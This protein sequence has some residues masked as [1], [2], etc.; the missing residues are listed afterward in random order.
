MRAENNLQGEVTSL[1]ALSNLHFASDAVAEGV[2]VRKE[3]AKRVAEMGDA[4]LEGELFQDTASTLLSLGKFSDALWAVNKASAVYRRLE[5][6][7]FSVFRFV[8]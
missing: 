5:D 6:E 8:T 7:V 4:N 3:A 2:K 1:V